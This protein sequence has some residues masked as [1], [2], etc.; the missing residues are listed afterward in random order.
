MVLKKK[1][2]KNGKQTIENDGKYRFTIVNWIWLWR[3]QIEWRQSTRCCTIAT[4]LW[5][6][7]S[8]CIVLS[9]SS[10]NET[11]NHSHI[12]IKQCSNC[13]NRSISIDR[14]MLQ[15]RGRM[16]FFLSFFLSFVI[17]F[18]TTL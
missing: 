1:N 14:N 2:E 8:V 3:I 12:G 11:M 7:A 5:Q 16:N 13:F 4:Q 9:T 6:L 10:S 18:L 15:R 17:L